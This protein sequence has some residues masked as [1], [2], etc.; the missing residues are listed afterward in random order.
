MKYNLD[1]IFF[2]NYDLIYGK[3]KVHELMLYTIYF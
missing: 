1:Q 2:S 3:M